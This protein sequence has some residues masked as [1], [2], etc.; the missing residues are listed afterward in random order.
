MT[1]K[2]A[3]FFWETDSPNPPRCFLSW[4]VPKLTPGRARRLIDDL[5]AADLYVLSPHTKAHSGVRV[6]ATGEQKPLPHTPADGSALVDAL[7]DEQYAEV[8]FTCWQGYEK[9][10]AAMVRRTDASTQSITLAIATVPLVRRE[11]LLTA[12]TP[13]PAQDPAGSLGFVLDRSGLAATQDWDR[14]LTGPGAPITTWPDTLA[15]P[16]AR[17]PALPELAHLTPDPDGPL[18]VFHRP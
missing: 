3:G 15:I 4:Y 5:A 8:G 10:A 14:I 2:R 18:A 7:T 1:T 12:L 13:L 17:I 6:T 16:P 11:K 9:P